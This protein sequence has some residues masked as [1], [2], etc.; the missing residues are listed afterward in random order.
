MIDTDKIKQRILEG[1]EIEEILEE[2]DWKEFEELVAE[3]LKKNG[4]KTHLN[5]R[6]K[7]GER[8]EI[9]IIAVK[10]NL[11]LVIDCKHWGRG[12][13]KKTGLKYAVED[14]EERVGELK[15]FLEEDPGSQK[16]LGLSLEKTELIPLIITWLEESLLK[17]EE[18]FIVPV[19]KLNHFLLNLSKYI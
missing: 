16:R 2:I 1:E 9:D 12:R 8:Y 11:S 17:Y 15:N 5:F 10:R 3:I 13:H 14:Q 7:T 18:T 6:F 19:W 4:F